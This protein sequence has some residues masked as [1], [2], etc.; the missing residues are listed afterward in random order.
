MKPTSTSAPIAPK[1]SK[2]MELHN[3][4]IGLN[5]V[6]LGRGGATNN[7][8]GNCRYRTIVADFQNEYLVA[9]KKEKV[10]ISRKIVAAVH[11]NGG[12]FLKRDSSGVWVEVPDKRA[13]EKTSQALR[14]GLCVRNN[15]IRPSKQVR[16]LA[17]PDNSVEPKVVVSGWVLPSAA[18]ATVS[19]VMNSITAP[20]VYKVPTLMIPRSLP[21]SYQPPVAKTSKV[22]QI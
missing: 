2:Q 16:R 20:V 4:A 10:V 18:P 19:P 21:M 11:A 9:R 22:C 17:K 8:E 7:H 14:E 1:S 13:T 5:D 12:R 3:C 6:L 15:T